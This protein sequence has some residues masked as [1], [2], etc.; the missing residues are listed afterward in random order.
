MKTEQPCL[1]LMMSRWIWFAGCA[2]WP[3]SSEFGHDRQEVA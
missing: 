2:E 3:R 1:L